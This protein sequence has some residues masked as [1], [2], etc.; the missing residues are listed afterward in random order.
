[1]RDRYGRTRIGQSLLLARRL[2]EAGVRYVGYNAFNQQWDTHHNI[3][4]NYPN[5][6]PPLDQAYSALLEDLTTR[7]L[8][9]TTLV[10]N[11]G[12]FGRTPLINRDGGRDHWPDVYSVTLAGGGIAGGQIYGASDSKG[13][14]VADRAVEPRDLL[15]TMWHLL[16][17]IPDTMLH[18]RLGRPIVLS[19]GRVMHDW[20]T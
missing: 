5:L 14:F 6:I 3:A 13:M 1:M 17:V 10:I 18:D 11:A 9:E 8:L 7:G 12:E 15:A 19:H 16:G 20:L 4:A 2:V